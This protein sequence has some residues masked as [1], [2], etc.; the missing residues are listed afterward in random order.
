VSSGGMGMGKQGGAASQVEP[1][2]W[3][4]PKVS[5]LTASRE[6][7][8][9]WSRNWPPLHHHVGEPGVGGHLGR[10]DEAGGQETRARL[11]VSTVQLL[12]IEPFTLSVQV[13][14]TAVY[15]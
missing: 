9:S 1:Q 11:L 3:P 2:V 7:S 5:R 12:G 10:R 15:Q 14:Q 13:L 8:R 4:V 6:W